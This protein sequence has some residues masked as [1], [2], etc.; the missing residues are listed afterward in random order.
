M[1][2]FFQEILSKNRDNLM[3]VFLEFPI[4]IVQRTNLS[5]FEPSWNTMEVEGVITHSPSDCTFFGGH[6]GLIGLAFNAEVH[7]VVAA[8]GAVVHH[9]IPGPQRH[10]VPLLHLEPLLVLALQRTNVK[11]IAIDI[12]QPNS[13]FPR[14]RGQQWASRCHYHTPLFRLI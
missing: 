2:N 14:W 9:D 3:T 12:P 11:Q 13:P 1:M 7:D 8:D 4:T 5:G 10:G 6:R